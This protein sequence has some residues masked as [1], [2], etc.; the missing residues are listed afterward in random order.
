MS[1]ILHTNA[2]APVDIGAIYRKGKSGKGEGRGK[3]DK[4]DQ[5]THATMEK[6]TV[7]ATTTAKA[8][9]RTLVQQP[10]TTRRQMHDVLTRHTVHCASWVTSL[11]TQHLEIDIMT[12]YYSL[13]R[14]VHKTFEPSVDSSW[15]MMFIEVHSSASV[16]VAWS[17]IFCDVWPRACWKGCPGFKRPFP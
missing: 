10:P 11:L 15:F 7:A 13:F 3:C 14:H 1:I 5:E 8:E 9:A 16:A 2:S 17:D 12:S 4:K 6:A